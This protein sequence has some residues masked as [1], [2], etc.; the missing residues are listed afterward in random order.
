M[1]MLKKL[2]CL[3]II[4]SSIISISIIPSHAKELQN[5]VYT[6]MN[7][8]I[9][10]ISGD[11][12]K[13]NPYNR[14]EDAVENVADGGIIYIVSSKGAFLNVHG[15]LPFVINKSVTIQSDSE[16]TQA[17]LVNRSAGIMLGGNVTFKNIELNFAYRYHDYIF[18]NGYSLTLDNTSRDSGHSLVD[19][20]GGG[21]YDLNGNHIG[22]ETGENAQIR[23]YGKNEFGN[24]YAGSINGKYDGNTSIYIQ[25]T[26]NAQIGEVYAS[27][28][29]ESDY[30]KDNWFDFTE[31][32]PPHPDGDLYP[33]NG[34]V[35]ILLDN[36]SITCVDGD[37]A[38]EG[39]NVSLSTN[40]LVSNLS[41][42]NI[43]Q[44][45]VNQGA[46]QVKELTS[47]SKG[48]MNVAINE[49]GTLNLSQYSNIEFNHFVGGG[50]VILGNQSTMKILGT[51]TGTTV[52]E[53]TGGYNGH[54]GIVL[55]NHV[56]IETNP[57]I[58][59]SFSYTPY[60]TQ[61]GYHF[62]QQLDG[63]WIIQKGNDVSIYYWSD[64]PDMGDVNINWEVI[65]RNNG[66]AEGATA[67]AYPGYHFTHWIDEEENVVSYDEHFIPQKVE[68]VYVE[69]G[70]GAIFAPNHYSVSFDA[71]GGIGTD[72]EKQ[73]HSYDD[74]YQLPINQY[75]KYGYTF[76]GWNTKRDGSG[77]HYANIQE[78]SGLTPEDN[79]EVVLYAQWTLNN[80]TIKYN[81]NGGTHSGNPIT[82]NVTS[83]TKILKSPTRKGYT[84]KGWYSDSSYRT[85]VTQIPSGSTGNKTFY[86]KW[87]LNNYTVKYNLNG[88]THSGNP[89]TYN[90]TSST[91]I[92]KNPA[93]KGY[94]FKGWYSDSSYRTKVT[95]I[96]SGSTGNK[97][98][99]AKWILNNYT[100]K[101]NLNKGKN[102]KSNPT[103][104]NV[105]SS[106][107]ILKNPTRKGYIFK[108]WYTS[109][110][111]KTKITKITKGS[112]GN[113][114]LYA[115]WCKVSVNKAKTPTITNIKGKKLKI[116]YKATTG[117]KGYQ[118]QYSTSK[119]FSKPTSITK[120]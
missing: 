22:P 85:K 18:A 29:K 3:F 8:S 1:T 98:F 95:Q 67:I 44:L 31:P 2:S 71:N 50:K 75:T 48:K 66:Q 82:Y 33:V 108:G 25:N 63:K 68:N 4:L 41:L 78:V 101:Y 60:P 72:I 87:T 7:G 80:Y 35:D 54:S 112:T 119:K 49:N 23:L 92:L 59:G 11:G 26:K 89:I 65:D 83:S 38:K 13:E 62:V 102:S 46:L 96:P 113:K 40:Y 73:Y 47:W 43:A 74:Q 111:Y 104:Y 9:N 91:K 55:A 103:T 37:G 19:I 77:T 105:T 52:F 109:N 120:T 64:Y 24:I 106:T 90:V 115:K 6:A 34:K 45:T 70:Y 110:Q 17:P 16:T 20:M 99:Y 88:G 79:A 15:E 14:F 97:T 32:L 36:A 21:L 42:K 76:K 114:T 30:D 57:K 10:S 28:A 12:T 107:K 56:Y 84:F 5:I 93:K 94:T 116:S 27:G 53:T 58:E 61:E 100:I 51:V 86:A 117:A 39:T 81:L 118:I 69:A